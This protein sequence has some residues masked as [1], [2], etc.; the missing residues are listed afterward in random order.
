[1][2]C[3]LLVGATFLAGTALAGGT[4]TLDGKNT[5]ITFVGS[6]PQGKHDGGFKAVS[7][8]ASA[9]GTDPTTLKLKL[10][11]DTTSLYTDTPK[12]TQHLKSPDFFAVKT[13]PKAKFVS[14][15]VEKSGD[16]YTITGDFTLLGKT[17]SI[18]IPARIAVGKNGLTIN[19]QF[20]INRQDYGMSFGTGK[21]DDEVKI[22]VAVNTK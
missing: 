4:F 6:K 8:S 1:M 19:S 13:H 5:K 9:D 7:G 3:A 16:G 21:V 18:A 22:K 11:I 12:L 14:N 2:F 17:K 10:D 15:K 20:T